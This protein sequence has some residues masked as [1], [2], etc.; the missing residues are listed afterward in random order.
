VATEL[1]RRDKLRRT[2][3]AVFVVACVAGIAVAVASTREVD[4]RGEEV[5]DGPAPGEVTFSGDRGALGTLPPPPDTGGDPGDELVE[6][7]FPPADSE[8]LQHVQVGVDLGRRY[9]GVL[10]VNGIEVPESQLVRRPAL[11]QV[12]FTP[13]EG[14]VLEQWQPGRNCVSAII[15]PLTSSRSNR[16]RTVDWCFE[17]T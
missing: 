11:N 6:Q 7:L 1:T 10:V 2:A 15:W 8:Q 14:L 16:S 12:F 13:G 3:I 4:D 9:T 5:T 17:V